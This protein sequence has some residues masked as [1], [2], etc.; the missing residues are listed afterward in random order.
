MPA[1]GKPIRGAIMSYFEKHPGVNLY[2]DDLAKDLNEEPKRIQQGI[3]NLIH[4]KTLDIQVVTRGQVY[5]YSPF[6]VGGKQARAARNKRVFEE[7]AEARDGSLILE[8]E[9]GTLY[10]A[11]VL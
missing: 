9:D 3:A 10:R 2:L 5:K 7:L 8:C 1:R 11:N 6:A 4:D